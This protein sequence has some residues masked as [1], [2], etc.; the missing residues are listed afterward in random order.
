MIEDASI[1][2][3]E[4]DRFDHRSVA[5][6]LAG[7]VSGV[8]HPT[9]VGLL[10]PFG[11]G[12][13]SVVRLLAEHLA[14]DG[15]LA[16]LQVSAEHHSGTA[17]ARAMLYGLL[18]AAHR[19][20]L[21][22]DE[23]LD[24]E[25]K[26]LAG[27]RQSTLPRPAPD[28]D[29]PGKPGLRRY[30]AAV[31][32]S[33]GWI[34][35]MVALLW[36]AGAI[37]VWLGHLLG[38]GQGVEVLAWFAAKG[39]A[40]LTAVLGSAAVASGVIGAAKEGA[41]YAYR[42]Y[43]ISVTTPRPDSTDELEQVFSRLIHEIH[44]KKKRLVIA[45][46]DIDRLNADEVLEALTTI[47]SLLLAGAHGSL[48]P[49][50]VISCDEDIVREAIMGVDP[51]LAHRADE[52]T[53]HGTRKATEEAA[54]EYLN[55]LFSVRI[56]LPVHHEHD[57]LGYVEHLLVFPEEH[58][59]VGRLGG[60]GQT[61]A[62]LETLIHP[63]VREPRHA[64]RLLNAFL[65]DYSLAARRETSSRGQA[66]RIAPGEVTG[67]PLELARLV[68]LRHD[69]RTLYD[70]IRR[71][72]AV[73][74]LLDDALYGSQA[75]LADPL[76]SPFLK[77]SGDSSD[78][79][80]EEKPDGLDT[81]RWPGLS[82]LRGTGWK[83]RTRRP[84]QLSALITL[85]SSAASR[86]LGSENAQAIALELRTRDGVALRRR[87]SGTQEEHR[88]LAAMRSTIADMKPGLPMGNAMAASV[89]ALGS[90]SDPASGF[91][92]AEE[93]ETARR[94]LTA[95]IEL[96]ARRRTEVPDALPVHTWVPLL[97]MV[98]DAYLPL[99][100]DELAACP[101]DRQEAGR[102]AKAL[103]GAATDASFSPR[104][105]DA[106]ADYFHG[107]AAAGEDAD[108]DLWSDGEANHEAWPPAAFG[109]LLAMA[110]RQGTVD[111]MASAASITRDNAD[112]HHWRR[113]V[114]LGLTTDW[115]TVSFPVKRERV[116]LL[117]ELVLPDDCWGPSRDG[118]AGTVASSLA[119]AV[120][121]VLVDDD[122]L[123]SSLK[124]QSLLENWLPAVGQQLA[125]DGGTCSTAIVTAFAQV[126][127]L[128]PE[129]TQAVAR[130]LPKLG[131]PDGADLVHSLLPGIPGALPG[132]DP[133]STTTLFTMLAAYIR[134]TDDVDSGP[135]AQAAQA[136]LDAYTAPLPQDSDAGRTVRFGL[137][138]V[139]STTRGAALSAQL[140]TTLVQH[141]P[142]PLAGNAPM[143]GH[144]G[145]LLASLHT[146]L[147]KP[148]VR[149]QALPVV[150]ERLQANIN[151]G[152]PAVSADFA[153][154]YLG[155][156]RV[157]QPWITHIDQHW[158]A[159]TP[160]ARDLAVRAADREDLRG[161]SL[162]ARL[163]QHIPHG[164][165]SAWP[166]AARL[167]P[168]A[169]QQT[170]ADMLAL[171]RGRC[172]ELAQHAVHAP[173]NVLD[174]A[175]RSCGDRVEDLLALCAGNPTLDTALADHLYN[176]IHVADMDTRRLEPIIDALTDP[177]AA[178][179]SVLRAAAEDQDAARNAA[180]VI[181][182]LTAGK[183][184]SAPADVADRLVPIVRGADLDATQALG[185]AV[186]SLPRQIRK[187]LDDALPRDTQN[188]ARRTAFRKAAR[189]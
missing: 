82:Y 157:A 139:L 31:R 40:P 148:A 162:V 78:V 32:A 37:T 134:H 29:Q 113:D 129:L 1:S 66:A 89:E 170:Q 176:L 33:A 79:L 90:L 152:Y 87:L 121:E 184:G 35:G 185:E 6:E 23:K 124:A 97:L 173:K 83:T 182:A 161:T 112:R 114:V 125:S 111:A 5:V 186:A 77:K 153:A 26:C 30:V 163:A 49:V 128:A 72:N 118:G 85:G 142:M 76:L 156:L 144:P 28:A 188:R 166:W 164:S 137:A 96:L 2:T 8:E 81:D 183:R 86:D 14:V 159:V 172:P 107:L 54:Q 132:L 70:H 169:D 24:S 168:S 41:I 178:W 68:V 102:W 126:A 69:F 99:L 95:L 143:A 127:F 106:V 165:D 17:R 65:S 47:R 51:G 160:Q 88:V 34:L 10:G 20:E 145:E 44:R 73:L 43:D 101:E 103:M 56:T 174:A 36:L 50:F 53:E 16:V 67:Y 48:V 13:S 140:V 133:A 123:T 64:I 15:K 92:S 58:P 75:A 141:L 55:K 108:L 80:D 177:S 4:Q 175:L 9:A 130:L 150:L 158:A 181:S 100:L 3:R 131:Q 171:A 149:Q 39:A 25:R 52:D 151:S 71:E 11:S 122:D 62:V 93:G 104:L 146:L 12:K 189:L 138:S 46:D 42:A 63:M 74:S 117:Q 155:D 98:P 94:E 22:S 59:V 61:R 45:I 21:I 19:A 187:K 110:A 136:A 7:L 105:V 84:P 115:E 109:A 147:A 180:V 119:C 60:I 27:A 38:R 57:L 167:W 120:A 116:A 179:E 154:R 135:V 18:G 91:S